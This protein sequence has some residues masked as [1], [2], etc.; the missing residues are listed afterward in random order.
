MTDRPPIHQLYCI[1]WSPGPGAL[2]LPFC[3]LLLPSVRLSSSSSVYL[4]LVIWH[5][6]HPPSIHQSINLAG[7]RRRKI[8]FCFCSHFWMPCLR[9]LLYC[10]QRQ[11][12]VPRSPC[13]ASLQQTLPKP[14]P[15][16]INLDSEY[17]RS[18]SEI[19]ALRKG[20]YDILRFCRCIRAATELSEEMIL[21]ILSS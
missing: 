12:Y 13:L 2:P 9:G 21:R 16:P 20:R 19:P 8:S 3:S 14:K 11:G 5:V 6:F 15:K 1:Y 18:R 7:E 17:V 4:V 10:G